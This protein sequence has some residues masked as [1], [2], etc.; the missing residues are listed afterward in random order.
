MVC[1]KRAA[2]EPARLHVVDQLA[3]LPLVHA[4]VLLSM[5]VATSIA[6]TMISWLAVPFHARSNA[7][8]WSTETRRNGS[9]T[10][11]LTPESPV[12]FF[13]RLV[14]LEAQRLDG[15]VP[16]VV[17]HGDDDIKLAAAGAREQRVGGQR[18]G[19]AQALGARCLDGGHDRV[20]LLVAEE[21][22]LAGVRV[23]AGHRDARRA[24]GR[25]P[26]ACAGRGGSSCSTRS[27]VTR[28]GTRRSA[29]WVVTWMTFS[30]L[31][32]RSIA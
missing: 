4:H 24:A 17:I 27:R 6:S 26:P 14:V 1:T 28:S 2:A 25:A 5:R 22:L 12:H 21:A 10:V 8:P 13:A 16:L 11:T 23:E 29:T 18:A 15:D 7:V 32:I 20:L 9:P 3:D 30:S 19:D 31:P